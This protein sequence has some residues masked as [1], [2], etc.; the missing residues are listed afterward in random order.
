MRVRGHGICYCPCVG[1]RMPETSPCAPTCVLVA[2]LHGIG[3]CGVRW[4]MPGPWLRD[5]DVS[6]QC[7]R[8]VTSRLCLEPRLR[9]LHGCGYAGGGEDPDLT[10]H[11]L[12]CNKPIVD[13]GVLGG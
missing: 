3:C 11:S 13:V 1:E 5:D 12:V 8:L 7:K 9:C 4:A 10:S 6:I 2:A